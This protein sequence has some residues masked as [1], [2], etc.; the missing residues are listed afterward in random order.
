[1]VNNKPLYFKKLQYML[2]CLLGLNLNKEDWRIS[3]KRK[4]DFFVNFLHLYTI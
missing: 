4:Q 3:W 1:M 2:I